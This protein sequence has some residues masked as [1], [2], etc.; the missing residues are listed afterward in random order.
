M[1]DPS[2]DG[3]KIPAP[4][5]MTHLPEKKIEYDTEAECAKYVKEFSHQ[6]DW[7]MFFNHFPWV[8]KIDITDK[9]D[10][11]GTFKVH[12][13]DWE[14]KY[15]HDDKTLSMHPIGKHINIDGGDFECDPRTGAFW[16]A[17]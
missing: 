12:H 5:L 1:C 17:W 3:N 10:G 14:F 2:A 13:S 15:M 16:M 4:F 6:Q 11:W 7:H 9:E 8:K